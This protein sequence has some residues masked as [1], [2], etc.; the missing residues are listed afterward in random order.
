MPFIRETRF[1]IRGHGHYFFRMRVERGHHGFNLN[2]LIVQKTKDDKIG[3]VFRNLNRPD[4]I[5]FAV[6]DPGSDVR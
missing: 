2:V 6:A 5:I 4:E 3:I 1:R